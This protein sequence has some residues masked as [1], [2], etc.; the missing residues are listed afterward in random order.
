MV[1]LKIGPR[2]VDLPYTVHLPGVSEEMFDR[3]TDEDTK[4]E[5]I[6]GVMVV[7][8]PASLRHDE[9]SGFLRSLLL[10][11]VSER[12]LGA[13][14]GP[15][16]VVRLGPRRKFAP[17]LYF[18]TTG[19]VP[20]RRPKQFRGVPAL[21]IEVLSPTN[22]N[23]DLEQ[24]RPLYHKAGVG[25]LWLVDPQREEV[26]RDVRGKKGYTT[27]RVEEGR[28]ESSVVPGFWVETAWLWEEPAP[29]FVACLRDIQG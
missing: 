18:L 16:S 14:F 25:E 23:V 21:V 4:A 29:N 7:H 3:L 1:E 24:K 9:V 6:D 28:L 15:D 17:D 10:G 27:V 22:R 20:R 8:S 19:Q 2:T 11:Y 26:I 13:V 5:L 12:G